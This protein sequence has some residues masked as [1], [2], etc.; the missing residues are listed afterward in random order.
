MKLVKYTPLALFIIMAI[1]F[2]SKIKHQNKL[3][4]LS[5]ALID[6]E[7]PNLDIYNSSKSQ[8]INNY[9]KNKPVII[10]I[11]ASWCA[12]CR[13]EHKV[14]KS[15]S[16]KYDIVGIAYKDSEENIE[17]FLEELGNPFDNIFYDFL[18]KESINLGLYGVP[19]TFFLNKNGKILY[20]HVGPINKEDF[21]K[22]APMILKH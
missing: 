20:K 10:N 4:P 19:E 22:L 2:Y 1:F 21:E 9:I 3:E 5:S 7:F 18:G 12:P 8:S 14:L 6:K 16:E 13:I 11:F 17:K 15:Y